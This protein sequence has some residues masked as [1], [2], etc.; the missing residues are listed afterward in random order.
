MDTCIPA[1]QA[2]NDA[3]ADGTTSGE[4]PCVGG[5]IAGTL[6]LM[7]TWVDPECAQAA[8]Q[9]PLIAR[10]IVSNLF[11]LRHH[12]ELGEPLRRVV[13]KV[14]ERWLPLA[15]ECPRGGTAAPGVH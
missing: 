6:A 5:L 11:F 3:D 4:L 9:R 12:P 13:G 1:S 7:T 15:R 14:H 8:R 2:A 10:K